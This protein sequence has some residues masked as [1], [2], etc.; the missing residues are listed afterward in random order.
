[1]HAYREAA[2]GLS[3]RRIRSVRCSV[4]C[5]AALGFRRAEETIEIL[6]RLEPLLSAKDL[7]K[8]GR[9]PDSPV[10]K[11]GFEYYIYIYIY[12]YNVL[13]LSYSKNTSKHFRF[14]KCV[15]PFPIPR[16]TI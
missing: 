16:S 11:L 2:L 14:N 7:T 4:W 1:M 12:I 9:C 15:L 3:V 10:I 8:E 13:Y 6:T 5:E